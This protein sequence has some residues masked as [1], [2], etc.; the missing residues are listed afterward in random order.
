MTAVD[1]TPMGKRILIPVDGSPQSGEAAAFAA[2]EWPDAEL[3][4]L[5][6]IDPVEAGYAAGRVPAAGEQWYEDAKE[7]AETFFANARD[8][9]GRDVETRTEVG[10]PAST[11]V[12]LADEEDADMIVMGSH[13]R[14]GLSRILLGSVAEH[15]LRESPVPVMVVR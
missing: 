12:E 3:L 9:A 8:A 6:V 1:T 13:G 2:E 10:R 5:H 4:A 7:R 14:E 11:I 15:V